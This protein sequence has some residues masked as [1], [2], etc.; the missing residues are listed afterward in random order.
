M[1]YL[2]PLVLVAH[3][4]R[5]WCKSLKTRRAETLRRAARE[6]IAR[7][8]AGAICEPQLGDGARRRKRVK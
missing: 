1:L 4:P 2:S 5:R 8:A 7:P 3:H 6:V